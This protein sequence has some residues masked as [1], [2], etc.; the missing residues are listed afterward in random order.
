MLHA[1]NTAFD[2]G[3]QSTD[4]YE[5]I[6]EESHGAQHG[7]VHESP[8]TTMKFP[9]GVADFQKIREENYLYVDRT[10]HKLYLFIDEYDNLRQ[11]GPGGWRRGAQE[12]LQGHQKPRLRPGAGPGIHDQRLAG[13]HE[14][15]RQRI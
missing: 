11:R 5:N 13:S 12:S 4:S 10:D 6:V 1:L 9:Y 3:Q 2:H 8:Y 15:H 7:R 14:R